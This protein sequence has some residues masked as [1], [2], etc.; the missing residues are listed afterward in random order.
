MR[1]ASAAPLV[2]VLAWW[3]LAARADDDDL[4]RLQALVEAAE[5]VAAWPLAERLEP[6]HAGAARFDLLYGLTAIHTGRHERAVY[7]FERLVWQRPDDARVRLELARALFRAGEYERARAQFGALLATDLPPR[8]RTR[9]RRYLAAIERRQQATRPRVSAYLRSAVGYD[10]NINNVTTD[11]R[12][13]VPWWPTPVELADA[14]RGRSSGFA[15]LEAF[16]GVRHPRSLR[17]AWFAEGRYRSWSAFETSDFDRHLLDVAG[18]PEW[19]RGEQ[20]MRIPV[21]LQTLFLDGAR[22]RDTAAAGAEWGWRP[23]SARALQ[24]FVQAVQSRYPDQRQRDSRTLGGGLHGAIRPGDRRHQYGVTIALGREATLRD[25]AEHLGR[26]FGL[27]RGSGQ[28]AISRNHEAY[29][30]LSAMRARYHADH[31]LFG[32]RRRDRQRQ[33]T[34]GWRWRLPG[35]WRVEAEAA[36][37]DNESTLEVFDYDQTV[38]GLAVRY[39]LR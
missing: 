3:S 9:L 24:A 15:E 32:A 13:S 26:S 11:K 37:A 2:A 21:R 6:E 34:L 12:V 33:L 29:A 5:Y 18:G 30:T 39:D 8:A 28:W 38:V 7:A 17:H 16:A 23:D 14:A 4:A 19:R 10:S 36:H 25:D 22:F 1:M 35:R 27:L 20:H 31:P